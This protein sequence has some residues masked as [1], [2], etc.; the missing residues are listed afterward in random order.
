MKLVDLLIIYFAIGAPFGVYQ[1]TTVRHPLNANIT[2]RT[3]LRI[4]FWPVF[5][6]FILADWFYQDRDLLASNFARRIESIRKEIEDIAFANESVSS[7]FDFREI[8]QR[9]AGLSEAANVAVADNSVNEVCDLSHSD[10]RKLASAC[11]ARKNQRKLSFHQ[12]LARSE[13]VDLI[14]E[15]AGAENRDRILELAIELA[16][17]LH[18]TPTAE[19]LTK[20]MAEPQPSEN[21][22][23]HSQLPENARAISHSASAI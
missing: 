6:V 8:L 20:L 18:D 23:A 11:L 16:N 15:L 14:F 1:I 22:P 19:A 10:N 9:Y 21:I 13:F 7:I 3:F 12:S 4:C 2:L 5:A 17:D